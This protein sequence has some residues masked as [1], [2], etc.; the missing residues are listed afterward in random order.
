MPTPAAQRAASLLLLA[1]PILALVA[2]GGHEQPVSTPIPQSS[3]VL[4]PPPQGPF[5]IHHH[6]EAVAAATAAARKAM[7]QL[8]LTNPLAEFVALPPIPQA[9][10]QQ[11]APPVYGWNV[12]FQAKYSTQESPGSAP[13]L[14]AIKTPGFT[15]PTAP[16]SPTTYRA[17]L[18][19]KLSSSSSVVATLPQVLSR[20]SPSAPPMGKPPAPAAQMLPGLTSHL[21]LPAIP[22]DLRRAL[23]P[24]ALTMNQSALNMSEHGGDRPLHTTTI[25]I[26]VAVDG[27]THVL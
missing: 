12:T 22:D 5:D 16:P 19:G 25:A 18:A 11:V 10:G 3:F 9:P 13:R 4:P 2:C 27:S 23:H 17:P 24:A 21:D 14:I 1:C 20:T 6:D 15:V 8:T 7:G 26:F